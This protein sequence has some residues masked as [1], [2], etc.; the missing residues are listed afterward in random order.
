M[1]GQLCWQLSSHH[2]ETGRSTSTLPSW[3]WITGVNHQWKFLQSALLPQ[4]ERP[5]GHKQM[6]YLDH[7][8]I[9]PEGPYIG[10][11][12][13]VW[14]LSCR[15]ARCD[16]SLDRY[17]CSERPP[18]STIKNPK[19]SC[20]RTVGHEYHTEGNEKTEQLEE[21]A[22][23]STLQAVAKASTSV[24]GLARIAGRKNISLPAGLIT[25]VDATGYWGSLPGE[26]GGI[27]AEPLRD[28]TH[29]GLIIASTLTSVCGKHVKLQ[30]ANDLLVYLKLHICNWMI[31]SQYIIAQKAVFIN[32][33]IF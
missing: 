22:W 6:A 4:E 25:T 20:A 2:C 13:L 8:K 15:S 33:V 12:E 21:T 7:S 23:T 9:G 1:R 28:K 10:Y 5:A 3:F 11:L 17:S 31:C 32:S 24:R 18:W 14:N 19:E 30:V 16:H 29:H 26:E 27:L